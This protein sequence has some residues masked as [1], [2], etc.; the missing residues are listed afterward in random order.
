M[1]SL[2][3]IYSASTYITNTDNNNNNYYY[4]YYYYFNDS[5][6]VAVEALS[7]GKKYN[8]LGTHCRSMV[9]INSLET[10]RGLAYLYESHAT[11]TNQ[12]RP[13]HAGGE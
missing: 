11:R 1:R 10:V 5:I 2:E 3:W 6:K 9:E 4:Y 13:D 12:S 7:E 8:F